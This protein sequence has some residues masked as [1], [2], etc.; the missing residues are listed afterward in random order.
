MITSWNGS[1][2]RALLNF[3][4]AIRWSTVDSSHK[5]P[6]MLD[7]SFVVPKQIVEQVVDR[8][9]IGD[10]M[11]LVWRHCGDRQQTGGQTHSRREMQI[12][13]DKQR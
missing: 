9:A 12:Q 3:C 4:E 1:S 8:P 6:V 13:Y 2:L 10:T 5:G 7:V 11:I